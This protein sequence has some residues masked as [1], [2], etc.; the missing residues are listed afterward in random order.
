MYCPRCSTQNTDD[1]KFCRS[2][3]SNL[4]LVPQALTGKLPEQRSGRRHRRRDR[5]NDAPSL[6]HGITKM[7]MGAGFVL[8]AAGSFFFAPAGHLWWFWLLIPAF[9]ML[10]RGV[11]EI[12]ASMRVPPGLPPI[13]QPIIPTGVRTG[14]LPPRNDAVFPPPSVTEDTTRQ[15]DPT[16]DPYRYRERH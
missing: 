7:F 5:D 3:G 14:E 16:T 8:A 13:S 12:V 1:T 6:E 9:A 4:S 2:C 15:L 11:A 10:G